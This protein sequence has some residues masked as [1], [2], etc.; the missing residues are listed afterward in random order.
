MVSDT[1]A[2]RIQQHY[3]AEIAEVDREAAN[4]AQAIIHQLTI[5][6]MSSA[7]LSLTLDGHHLKADLHPAARARLLSSITEIVRTKLSIQR[8]VGER[9]ALSSNATSMSF[10][11]Q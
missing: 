7:D 6:L 5:A 2:E 9:A 8:C 1:L 4:A 10:L 3:A 11:H